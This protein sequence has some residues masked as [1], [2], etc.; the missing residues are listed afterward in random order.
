MF[1]CAVDT[2]CVLIH[3]T[4]CIDVN[5]MQRPWH[6]MH[7]WKYMAEL[8]WLQYSTW[9]DCATTCVHHIIAQWVPRCLRSSYNV[10][11]LLDKLLR[12]TGLYNYMLRL[13]VCIVRDIVA[14]VVTPGG[15]CRSCKTHFWL[16][17]WNRSDYMRT[18]RTLPADKNLDVLRVHHCVRASRTTP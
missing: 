7:T 8:A 14:Q 13:H 15:W 6:H 12:L 3:Y 5:F 17:Y 10:K 18:S 4:C 16:L 1:T 11:L 9:S 2:K